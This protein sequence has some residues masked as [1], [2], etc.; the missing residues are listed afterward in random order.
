MTSLTTDLLTIHG[1]ALTA[2]MTGYIW[3]SDRS[4]RFE[5]SFRGLTDTLD[6]LR[7]QVTESLAEHLRPVFDNPGSVAS[8]IVDPSGNHFAQSP[9]NPVES[10]AYRE[11]IM[12]FVH[13]KP[14]SLID[15]K[16]LIQIRD[17]WLFWARTMSW[18]I[19]LTLV[20]EVVLTAGIFIAGKMMSLPIEVNTGIGS[21]LPTCVSFLSF[22]GAAT[23]MAVL[24]DQFVELRKQYGSP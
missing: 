11:A 16:S 2:A 3:Y 5:K 7:R 23:R 4:E 12:S 18:T 22:V 21:L 13:G 1:A 14:S 20:A 8:V 10:E 9:I 19:L 24:H 6:S 17:K 15:L